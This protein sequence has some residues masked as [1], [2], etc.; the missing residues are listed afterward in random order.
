LGEKAYVDFKKEVSRIWGDFSVFFR[1]FSFLFRGN[2]G[3]WA[4]NGVFGINS[5]KCALFDPNLPT[6]NIR[7]KKRA[8]KSRGNP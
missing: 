3:F 8:E 7:P 4:K 6:L 1:D 5:E 2:V